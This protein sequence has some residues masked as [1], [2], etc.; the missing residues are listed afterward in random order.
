MKKIYEEMTDSADIPEVQEDNPTQ[1]T[2]APTL[3]ISKRHLQEALNAA[4]ASIT[5]ELGKAWG[6]QSEAALDAYV[7][8]LPADALC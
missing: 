6:P 2:D 7:A 5:T 3:P 1:F 8:R 4:G